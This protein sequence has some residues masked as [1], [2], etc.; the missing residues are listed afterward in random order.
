MYRKQR[1]IQRSGH[2]ALILIWEDIK[3]VIKL[4]RY[5]LSLPALTAAA[6]SGTFTPGFHIFSLFYRNIII[7]NSKASFLFIFIPFVI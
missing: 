3:T 1:I 7:K 5:L 4:M 6:Q 2:E